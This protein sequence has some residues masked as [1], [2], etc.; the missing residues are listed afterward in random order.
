[1]L[2]RENTSRLASVSGLGLENVTRS[3]GATSC[4]I[5]DEPRK[6]PQSWELRRHPAVDK[7]AARFGR[8][9]RNLHQLRHS[10]NTDTCRAHQIQDPLQPGT[11]RFL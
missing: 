4:H 1:M 9:R 2:R 6:Q 8:G 3:D 11:Q 10:D 7:A 5:L